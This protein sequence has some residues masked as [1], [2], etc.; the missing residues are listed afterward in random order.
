[1]RFKKL[2]NILIIILCVINLVWLIII[3]LYIKDIKR[4]Q[5]RSAEFI[6]TASKYVEVVEGRKLI[7]PDEYA[8]R[9]K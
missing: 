1:M 5:L 2:F 9:N 6:E 7:D 3:S 8:K 4:N